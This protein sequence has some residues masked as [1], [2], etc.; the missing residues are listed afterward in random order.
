MRCVRERERKIIIGKCSSK[1]ISVKLA[2][3]FH[4]N[5]QSQSHSVRVCKIIKTARTLQT[6][7]FQEEKNQKSVKFVEIFYAKKNSKIFYNGI[8]SIWIQFRR[9]KCKLEDFTNVICCCKSSNTPSTF[10]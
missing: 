3:N 4:L 2:R 10:C 7:N 6:E 5:P 9:F 1:T 8:K